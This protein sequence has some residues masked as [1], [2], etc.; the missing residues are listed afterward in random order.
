MSTQHIAL[1]QQPATDVVAQL[2]ALDATA[3]GLGIYYFTPGTFET[4][5]IVYQGITYLPY[6]IQVTGFELTSQGAQPRPKLSISNIGGFV[7]G[8]VISGKGLLGAK[9]TRIRTFHRFLD[10]GI[11]ADPD[12]HWPPQTFFVDRKSKHDKM[13]IEW[14]LATP[15]DSKHLKIPARMALR[16]VCDLKYRAFNPQVGQ[17][18]YT[19]TTCPYPGGA[20]SDQYFD[21]QDLAQ[22]D[23]SKDG[24]SHKLSGCKLRYG[25]KATLPFGGFPGLRGP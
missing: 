9:L 11:N 1:A 20:P 7:G 19:N 15:L 4:A 16:S 13:S 6:P 17:F 5:P 21:T 12:A 3:L 24:C 10:N 14:E 23:P 8:L 2:F 18:N 22:T 25:Q